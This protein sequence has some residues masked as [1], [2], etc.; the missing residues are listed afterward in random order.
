MLLATACLL[1]FS[2]T[3]KLFTLAKPVHT[4]KEGA[5]KL[6]VLLLAL[7]DVET[8]QRGYLLM[9]KKEFLEKYYLAQIKTDS[10]LKI[11]SPVLYKDSTQTKQ[12]KKLQLL[13]NK[14]AAILNNALSVYAGRGNVLTGDVKNAAYDDNVVMDSIRQQILSMQAYENAKAFQQDSAAAKSAAAM[15]IIN[16]TSIIISI[17]AA[18][19]SSI[20][21]CCWFL[22]KSACSSVFCLASFSFK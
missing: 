17:L 21:C 3:G 10:I 7:T 12:L 1:L 19:N 5:D 13:T 18:F 8:S 22:Y 11:T 4:A 16:F 6:Q 20:L 2:T 9:N 15:M 14:N